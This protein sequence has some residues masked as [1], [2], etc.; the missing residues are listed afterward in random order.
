MFCCTTSAAFYAG[1]LV[2]RYL[3]R[4]CD[5]EPAPWS[6]A[7]IG[8]GPWEEDLPDDAYEELEADD[9]IDVVRVGI[10]SAER[11]QPHWAYTRCTW[12][13][14]R[15]PPEGVAKKPKNALTG[16]QKQKRSVRTL[17]LAH[18]L[19]ACLLLRLVVC[20]PHALYLLDLAA[21]SVRVS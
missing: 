1:K 15:P 20:Q 18:L 9:A 16:L 11:E 13:W 10:G 7:N 21:F 17:S 8:D 6:T 19:S 14:A 4:R 5:N 3:L 2:C 12:G